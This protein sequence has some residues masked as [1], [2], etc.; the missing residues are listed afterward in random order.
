MV[1]SKASKG[2]I[3]IKEKINLTKLFITSN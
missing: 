1:V 3:M 2:Q